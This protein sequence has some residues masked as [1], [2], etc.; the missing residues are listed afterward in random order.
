MHRALVAVAMLCLALPAV[1]ETPGKGNFG[2]G[3]SIG[4]STLPAAGS[5]TFENSLNA[6]YFITQEILVMSAIGLSSWEKVGTKFDIYA[7]CNYY[8]LRGPGRQLSPF[9]GGIFGVSSFSPSAANVDSTTGIIFLLGGGLE[10]FFNQSFSI[11]IAEGL[12]FIT[13]PTNFALVTR[14]GLTL[15]I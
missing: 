9:V 12:Q 3:A 8:F 5:V 11:Q 2:F 7:G 1:A 14:L 4:Y 15:F 10:Y 13:K 6:R